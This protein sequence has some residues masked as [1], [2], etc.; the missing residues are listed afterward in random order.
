MICRVTCVLLAVF[1]AQRVSADDGV[2]RIVALGDSITRG[3]RQGVTRA[4]TFAALLEAGLK[5]NGVKAEV[6]NVGIGGERADQALKRLDKDVIAR[7]PTLVTIMYGTNDSYVDKGQK[8]PRISKDQYAKELRAIVDKLKNAG[9]RPLLMT[10]PRWGDGAKNGAGEDPNIRLEDY[11]KACRAVA[12]ETRT[13]LVDHYDHWS[14]ARSKGT[15]IGKWTT[16]LCH[17]NFAGNREINLI[18][19]PVVMKQLSKNP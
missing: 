14:K 9:I 2:I 10:E 16:D 18:L 11:L 15:D 12:A 4:Q 1:V 3:V 5:A 17:P 7:K 13:P 8:A 6:M 19:L